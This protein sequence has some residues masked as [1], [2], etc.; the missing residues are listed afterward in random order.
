[1]K[2]Y[3]YICPFFPSLTVSRECIIL[4]LTISISIVK[5]FFSIQ[6]I[7]IIH[8]CQK[9]IGSFVRSSPSLAFASVSLIC[10]LHLPSSS[11]LH[12]DTAGR[13]GGKKRQTGGYSKFSSYDLTA[14]GKG[15]NK[16]MEREIKRRIPD[17]SNKSKS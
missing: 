13:Q 16:E 3:L 7:Y 9:Y 5:F 1:M 8:N 4:T 12:I 11:F 15:D 17:A 14:K 6:Y 2:P 10:H